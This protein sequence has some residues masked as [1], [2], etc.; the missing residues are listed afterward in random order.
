MKVLLQ[1]KKYFYFSKVSKDV[2]SKSKEAKSEYW[3][4]STIVVEA[5]RFALCSKSEAFFTPNADLLLLL[6][7]KMDEFW[8]AMTQSTLFR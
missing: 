2:L 5:T 4:C 7:Y 1:F 6:Y 3:L 8:C